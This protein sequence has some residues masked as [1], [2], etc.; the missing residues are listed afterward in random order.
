MRARLNPARGHLQALSP[1]AVLERGYA[2]AFKQDTGE[3]IRDASQ[4]H[5]GDALDVR[6]GKGAAEV[7]V[8]RIKDRNDGNAQL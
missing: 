3:L 7:A 2:L 5:T 4:L 8:K 1:V 6:F